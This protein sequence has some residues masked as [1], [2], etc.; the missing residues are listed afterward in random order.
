MN[1]TKYK[2]AIVI[3]PTV[4]IY[5]TPSYEYDYPMPLLITTTTS[6]ETLYPNTSESKCTKK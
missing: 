5:G 6:K 4:S 3:K 1:E 2:G